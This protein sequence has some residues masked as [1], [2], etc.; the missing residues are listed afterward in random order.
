MSCYTKVW[1]SSPL[2]HSVRRSDEWFRWYST[3]QDQVQRISPSVILTPGFTPVLRFVPGGAWI[4][5]RGKRSWRWDDLGPYHQTVHR[6]H[7]SVTWL[8]GSRRG[9]RCSLG[10]AMP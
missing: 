8:C 1:E 5:T 3:E 10:Y 9:C 2:T 7:L 6:T 4:M